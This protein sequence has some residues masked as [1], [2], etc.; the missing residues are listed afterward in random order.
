VGARR[1]RRQGSGQ[2][3]R[4]HD[5][6]ADARPRVPAD[7]AARPRRQGDQARVRGGRQRGHAPGPRAGG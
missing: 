1:D 7:R 2:P 3:R 5:P 4:D 6:Q